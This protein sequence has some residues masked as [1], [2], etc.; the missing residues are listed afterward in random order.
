MKAPTPRLC[1]LCL[2]ASLAVSLP[3]LAQETPP[4]PASS[5][6]LPAPSSSLPAAPTLSP[7]ALAD[8]TWFSSLGVPDVKGLPFGQYPNGITYASEDPA[9]RK[10]E[11]FGFLLSKDGAN[12][13]VLNFDLTNTTL[14]PGLRDERYRVAFEPIS[15]GDTASNLVQALLPP[16]N[17][18]VPGLW[19]FAANRLHLFIFAWACWRNDLPDL[20]AQLYAAALKLPARGPVTFSRSASSSPLS[21]ADFDR[22]L[23]HDLAESAFHAALQSFHGSPGLSRPDF[24]ACLQTIQ[25]N[26]PLDDNAPVIAYFIASIRQTIAE[27]ASHAPIAPADIPKLS[28]EA[29]LA[30]LIYQLRNVTGDGPITI[31]GSGPWWGNPFLR[32]DVT[33]GPSRLRSN[34]SP[35]DP[36]ST[37]DILV[38]LGPAAVPS[39]LNVL[40]DTTCTRNAAFDGYAGNNSL[41]HVGQLALQIL[42]AIAQRPF[43]KSGAYALLYT[44]N[45]TVPD[46]ARQAAADWW[47]SYQS[48]G[49]QQTLIDAVSAADQNS[50]KQA[51]V[52]LKKYPASAIAALVQGI[53]HASTSGLDPQ[54]ADF[55]RK[56]STRRNLVSLLAQSGDPAATTALQ[57]V[58]DHDPDDSIR[59]I[60]ASGLLHDG[61]PEVLPTVIQLWHV[62]TARFA[63]AAPGTRPTI[64]NTGP[65]ATFLAQA[66]DPAALAAIAADLPQLP[67]FDRGVALAALSNALR[68]SY[69]SPRWP[70]SPA[71]RD[72]F[73]QIFV[74]QLAD[75]STDS[76]NMDFMTLVRGLPPSQPRFCDYAAATLAATFPK[77]Y[78]FKL[79]A[80]PATRDSQIAAI[81]STYHQAHPSPP[82]AP[83]TPPPASP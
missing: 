62:N 55:F 44:G 30:E 3:A 59:S 68:G 17:G 75:A 52:L 24:L 57:S 65:L 37:A 81:L 33:G 29:F 54:S 14:G 18:R 6:S 1:F 39:L 4:P 74:A 53:A 36:T 13:T 73:E 58:F 27:D 28:D 76:D 67:S 63:Q 64:N 80:P 23:K 38:V 40:A 66:D 43:Y 7:D 83:A 10:G 31:G 56:T 69:N 71:T 47:A 8:F 72:A 22:A 25:K 32:Y 5:S 26:F 16:P 79:S 70:V 35:S 60:A 15:L 41:Q 12:S 50:Y 49:E 20:A 21:P 19:N 48:K 9:H 61:H 45:V 82:S 34:P 42:E 11:N 51:Q 77:K 78:K 46:A 2:A